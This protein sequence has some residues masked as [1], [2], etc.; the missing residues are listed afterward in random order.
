M[1]EHWVAWSILIHSCSSWYLHVNVHKLLPCL[2]PQ[3]AVL[4]ALVLQPPPC[5][6]LFPPGCLSLLLLPVWMN[7]SSLTPW[8]L[9][10]HTVR[11]SVSSGCFLFLNFLSFF[12]LWEEA[13]CVYLHLHLGHKAGY[14]VLQPLSC[15]VLT[16]G[17]HQV[18]WDSC[19]NSLRDTYK[20]I[21]GKGTRATASLKIHFH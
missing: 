9:D 4:P 7:V 16:S 2:V 14:E 3:P 13:Q 8:L 1:L 5:H 11:F 18:R 6:E 19:M 21:S 20:E 17:S 12:W 10:F 15:P